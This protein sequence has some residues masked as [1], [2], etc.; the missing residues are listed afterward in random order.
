[1]GLPLPETQLVLPVSSDRADVWRRTRLRQ[2]W[3]LLAT[4]IV[5]DALMVAVALLLAWYLRIGSGLLFYGSTAALSTYLQ[6]LPVAVLIFVGLFALNGLYRYNLLLGGP[7]E[8][9]NVFRA[10]SYGI[11]ALVFASYVQGTQPL[12]R[13]WL[14]LAWVLLILLVGASRFVKAMVKIVMHVVPGRPP[15]TNFRFVDTVEEGY[16]LI[17]EHQSQRTPKDSYH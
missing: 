14:V 8:Y 2:R 13:G 1:M 9:G 4:L 16:T 17:A 3:V 11:L 15:G 5:S 12:S 10:C 6:I 7:Q